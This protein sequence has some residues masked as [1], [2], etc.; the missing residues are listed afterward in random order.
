MFTAFDLVSHA[1]LRAPDRLAL[2]DDMSARRFTYR[3]LIE[4]IERIAAG[5][6]ERGVRAGA[7]VATVLNNSIDHGLALLALQRIGAVPALLNLRLSPA[8]I[9]RL[10]QQ[11]GLSAAILHPLP[12]VVAAAQSAL[13]TGAPLL[14]VGG[15]VP[16]T[17]PFAE[18]RGNPGSL[19]A[20]P[21]PGREDPAFLFYTSGTTGLPKAVVI[22]HRATELLILW[23]ET[24]EG[25][26]LGCI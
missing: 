1:S 3:E 12:E 11:G 24:Q 15:A 16:G 18:C 21:K 4:E 17:E 23:I 19:P 6:A 22:P 5:L 13:P 8:D 14:S 7:R 10:M 20:P 25:L 2:I 9:G 26:R